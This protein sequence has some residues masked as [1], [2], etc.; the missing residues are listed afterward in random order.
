MAKNTISV[1]ILKELCDLNEGTYQ[2]KKGL[3]YIEALKKLYELKNK[4]DKPFTTKDIIES[5]LL[6]DFKFEG[7]K[8]F[9]F[10]CNLEAAPMTIEMNDKKKNEKIVAKNFVSDAEK[11]IYRKSMGV[12]YLITCVID[13][14]EHIIKIGSTRTAFK[15]R[16]K[17]YNCGTISNWRTASTTNI[18]MLQSMITTRKTFNLYIIDCSWDQQTYNLCGIE[19]V[20]FASS[21]ALAYEDILV[22]E[23]IKQFKQKP[24]ANVQTNATEVEED[25]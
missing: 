9:K 5:P 1:E 15:D 3:D 11:K 14:N 24:L 23:Y 17:S 19:S 16:L 10:I 22:K 13:K 20:P 2:S 6:K 4:N 25:D 7:V 18:K 12:T 21:R 8:K